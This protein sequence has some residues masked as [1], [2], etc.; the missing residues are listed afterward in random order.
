MKAVLCAT[1]MVLALGGC[2]PAGPTKIDHN[3]FKLNSTASSGAGPAGVTG[4]GNPSPGTGGDTGTGGDGGTGGDTGTGG[5]G[6]NGG[7]G[8]DGGTGGGG[9]G[10]GS[11]GCTRSGNQNACR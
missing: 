3:L 6:G 9:T 11:Q 2:V 1:A 8:G 5:D 10:G 7:A 4:G